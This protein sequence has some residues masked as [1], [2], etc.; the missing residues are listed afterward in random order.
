MESLIQFLQS[1]LTWLQNFFDGL[2]LYLLGPFLDGINAFL[3]WIPVPSFFSDAGGYISN[4]PPAAAYFLQG[5]N[6]APGFTMIVSAY[7]I[8]FLIRR[9]PFFG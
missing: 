2:P 4:I 8:R 3:Q 6:I 1:I 7:I 9:I 5:F